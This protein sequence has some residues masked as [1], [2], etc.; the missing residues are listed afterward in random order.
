MAALMVVYMDINDDAWMPAYFE[1]VTPIL[2]EYGATPLA[3]SR[4]VKRIEGDLPA[5]DRL[6]VLSF[7]SEEA[8]DRFME[9]ERYRPYRD[10]R[11]AASN[12]DIFVFENEIK[13][14]ELV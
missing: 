13:T 12:A 10:A 14:R 5:P 1:A 3:G 8:I 2:A 7:P 9:D 4:D 6:L 11:R